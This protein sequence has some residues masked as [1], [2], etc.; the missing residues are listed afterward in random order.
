[1]IL[2]EI[3]NGQI[4]NGADCRLREGKNSSRRSSKLSQ[5]RFRG[6]HANRLLGYSNG[7]ETVIIIEMWK[8]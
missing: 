2:R 4:M 6:R 7:K 3:E 8:N 1:M 5:T